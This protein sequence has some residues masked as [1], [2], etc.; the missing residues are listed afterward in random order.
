MMREW[1]IFPVSDDLMK[2]RNVIERQME[3]VALHLAKNEKPD[4]SF[5]QLMQLVESIKEFDKE[6]KALRR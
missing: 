1:K 3:E 6:L 5:E 2:K 4:N